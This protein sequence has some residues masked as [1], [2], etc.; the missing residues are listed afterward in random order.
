MVEV[1]EILK[2]FEF[3]AKNKPLNEKFPKLYTHWLMTYT[4]IDIKAQIG[5]AHAWIVANPR[6]DKKDYARFI[7]NWLCS[8]QMR[9]EEKRI[10]V[11]KLPP[12]KHY[13]V[14][15]DEV[16]EGS[17]FTKL[18]E[19]LR[20]RKRKD[21]GDVS[22]ERIPDNTRESIGNSSGIQDDFTLF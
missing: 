10:I 3:F 16:M 2:P 4:L 17:D 18:K 21:I 13:E 19:A 11:H 5:Y 9:A 22:V 6:R 1:Q 8:A 20:E 12:P 15:E 7:N 14:K